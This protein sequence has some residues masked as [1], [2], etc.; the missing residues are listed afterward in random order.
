MAQ[1]TDEEKDEEVPKDDTGYKV[2]AKVSVGDLMDKDKDDE[3]LQKYKAQLL[4]DAKDK[5]IDEKD[6]RQV[7]FEILLLPQDNVLY[8][9]SKTKQNNNIKTTKM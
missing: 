7:Q 8:T 1:A 2:S 9:C 5:I 3:A 4:G 6:K